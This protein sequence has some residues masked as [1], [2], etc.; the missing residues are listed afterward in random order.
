MKA[1][2]RGEFVVAEVLIP[3]ERVR[4]VVPF[5]FEPLTILLRLRP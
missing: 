2:E 3:R 1:Q 5:P 4:D